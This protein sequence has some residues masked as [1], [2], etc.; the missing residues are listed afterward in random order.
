V[1]PRHRSRRV[2]P[3][4]DERSL[5]DAIAA[6]ELD[7]H[8]CAL[9]AAVEARRML[10]L[11]VR[12]ATALATLCVGDVV[13]ITEQVSPRYLVGLHGTVVGLDD[14][15]ATVRLEHPVGRFANGR[16]RCP[17]LTLEKLPS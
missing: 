3:G 7:D 10:L 14:G 16:V 8:L 4:E 9:A 1:S 2:A 15:G 13:R 11:T 6:G 5:L 17:P 12:S